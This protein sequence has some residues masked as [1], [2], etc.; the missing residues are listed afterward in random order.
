MNL[1]IIEDEVRVANG[2]A[3]N[4]DW[5]KHDIAV[6]G[7]S[8]NGKEALEIIPKWEPDIII[9]D[10]HMPEMDGL[11]LAK[12]IRNEY[13]SLPKIIILSGHDDFYFAQTAIELG[14]CQ[15]LLKPAGDEEIRRAVLSASEEIKLEWKEQ[16]NLAKLKKKWAENLPQLQELFFQKWIFGKYSEYETLRRSEEFMLNISHYT[17]YTIATVAMDPLH[18]DDSTFHP[19][20]DVSLLTFSL[21]CIAQECLESEKCKVI[22]NLNESIIICFL[23]NK[24]QSEAAVLHHVNKQITKLLATVKECLGV[25]ASAGIGGIVNEINKVHQSYEKAQAALKERLMYGGDIVIPQQTTYENEL[26]FTT[27]DNVEK[28]IEIALETRNL[29]ASL[30]LM[31]PFFTEGLE[32]SNQLDMIREK[33]MYVQSFFIKYIQKQQ[34]SITEVFGEEWSDFNA[35]TTIDTAE[36]LK[37]WLYQLMKKMLKYTDK[38]RDCKRHQLVNEALMIIEKNMDQEITLNQVSQSLFVNASYLSRLFKKEMEVS[39]SRYVLVRKMERA[40]QLLAQGKKVYFTAGVL[41]Y[42][43]VSYFSKVFR[44]HWGI[45]PGEMKEN[46]MDQHI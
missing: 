32:A 10:I 27:L 15:Y 5:E 22:S 38:K 9:L 1:M 26:N 30:E 41:G 3:F 44:K 29:D 12:S 31:D 34:W 24:E 43:D 35:W 33:M 21:K 42:K 23:D 36:E 14:V 17:K 8:N 7:I 40:K 18:G 39:F 46:L 4:I 45:T 16:N 20:E 28:Q 37:Q 13:K 2:I 19:E 11:Q 6:V 25:S